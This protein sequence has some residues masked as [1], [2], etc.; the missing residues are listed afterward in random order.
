MSPLSLGGRFSASESIHQGIRPARAKVLKQAPSRRR[1]ASMCGRF[2]EPKTKAAKAQLAPGQRRWRRRVRAPHMSYRSK[3]QISILRML[4]N[5]SSCQLLR[6]PAQTINQDYF[7]I[8]YV[9]II[10]CGTARKYVA[11]G[12]DGH[13]RRHAD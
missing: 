4:I 5:I 8:K 10:I 9:A 3:S 1:P 2:D 13:T 12:R 7:D 11:D 6:Q